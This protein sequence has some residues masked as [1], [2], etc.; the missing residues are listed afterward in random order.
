VA[1][2]KKFYVTSRVTEE[3]RRTDP[4][5]VQAI[6][7]RQFEFARTNLRGPRGGRYEAV[8]DLFD[9]RDG[10]ADLDFMYGTWT[11]IAHQMGKYVRPNRS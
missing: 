3:L 5:L 10:Q 2:I 11:Y 9:F 1:R 8:G 4:D 7:A 6:V